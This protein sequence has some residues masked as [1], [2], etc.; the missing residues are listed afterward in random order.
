MLRAD[1]LE[2]LLPFW[3]DRLGFV[4]TVAVDEGDALGFVVLESDGVEVMLQSTASRA[5]ERDGGLAEP[6]APGST[7]LYL[8]V[9]DLAPYL[10]RLLPGDRAA[11]DRGTAHGTRELT[12]RDPAGHEV[13]LSA[14]DRPGPG[15]A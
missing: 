1:A 8:E 11:P 7:S 3:R 9:D 5:R 12:L 10:D 6:A 15:R 14:P 4:V 2:P 13:V